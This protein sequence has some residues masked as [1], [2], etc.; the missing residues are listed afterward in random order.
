MTKVAA[1]LQ[2]SDVALKKT[3][4]RHCVPAPPRGYWARK[5][6]GKRVVQTRFFETSDP[7][8]GQ[9]KSRRGVN[10]LVDEVPLDVETPL[11]CARF[12]EPAQTVRIVQPTSLHEL[13]LL[14][15]IRTW[16]TPSCR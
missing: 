14:V 13:E 12:F 6:A 15:T 3:C 7:A 9:S 1:D 2:I 10:R 4:D 5:A 8:V 11:A 16:P